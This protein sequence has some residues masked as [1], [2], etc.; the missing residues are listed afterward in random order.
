MEESKAPHVVIIPSPGMGHLIPLTEFAKRLVHHHGFNV[1]FIVGGEGPPSKAQR[2]VLGSLPSSI[3]SVFLP[4][5]DLTDVPSSAGIETRI[6]LTVTRSNPE[7]RKHF[8]SFAAEGRLPKALV[9]D[10][11]GTDAFDVASEFHVSPY[12]FYPS[13]ANVLSFFLHLPKLDETVSC[14][15]RELTEPV[16]LPGCVPLAGK[17]L[18]DPVQ[19]RK[20]DAYKWLLHNTKRY[21]E[22]EGILVNSFIEL[23]PKAIKA[24]QEPGLD[25]P[26][27]Y[28]VGPLVNIG[29]HETKQTEE[30]EC[31]TWLDNQ[32]LGSVLYVS[33]GS[34]GT[35]TREQ[36]NELALGLADSEQR[37][38]WVIRT[39]SGDAN[40]SY[41]DSHSQNDPLSF[42]P[43][44]FLERTKDRG[45]V[46]PSWAPQTQVLAHPSTGGFLTHCGWN[47]TLESVVSGIPLIAWPLYAEQKMN[48]VLLTEDIRAALRARAGEDGVV[49]REEVARVVKGLMEGEEGKGVRNKMKELKE[50]ASR[51]LK[52]DGSS[53]KALSLVA[54]KW[55][56]NNKQLEQNGNH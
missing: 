40:S 13:T 49:R 28:P 43:P 19:D 9:V 20:I 52:D 4:P 45:F 34:G 17:D 12:I 8:D 6:S 30:C 26:P 33:F 15:F 25:K 36:L 7:L 18:L 11:F 41:F 22:A 24:L 42:L 5:V 46:I 53:T 38:L 3:S 32:P 55:K 44:G 37:F 23:E 31:L 10:L 51:V 16:K 35:L 56:A 29:K 50:G 27:V 54:L 2:T 39:P 47:S 14:E 1:T 21:K 48:A